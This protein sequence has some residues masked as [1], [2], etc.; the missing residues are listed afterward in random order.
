MGAAETEKTKLVVQYVVPAA[1]ASASG[2]A[3]ATA[4]AESA[5]D[6]AKDDQLGAFRPSHARPMSDRTRPHTSSLSRPT[7]DLRVRMHACVDVG[8]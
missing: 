4:T 3:A 2:D 1:V 6:D 7:A 8:A 5:A